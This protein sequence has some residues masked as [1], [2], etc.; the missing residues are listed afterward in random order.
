LGLIVKYEQSGLH[1]LLS[2]QRWSMPLINRPKIGKL[3]CRRSIHRATL[4]RRWRHCLETAAALMV[5][6]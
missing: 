2:L 3:A 4:P 6:L 5:E 1:R